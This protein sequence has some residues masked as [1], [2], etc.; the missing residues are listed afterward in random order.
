MVL[1]RIGAPSARRVGTVSRPGPG[2]LLSDIA[3]CAVC[4]TAKD[5]RLLVNG[6]L[7]VLRSGAQ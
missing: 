7:G 2:Q 1:E 6:A 5:N 3:A 4:L